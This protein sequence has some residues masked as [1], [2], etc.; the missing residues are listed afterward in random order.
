MHCAAP[1]A[2]RCGDCDTELPAGA[3]FCPQCAR[4]A[5]AASPVPI[6][7]RSPVAYTSK[8]RAAKILPSKFAL[9]GERKQV[10]VLFADVKGSL[11]LAEQ[12]DADAWH[13][14]LECFFAILADGAHRF[15]GTV[16]QCTGDGIMALF[17]PSIAH[18]DHAQRACYAGLYVQDELARYAS[19]LKRAQSLS[20]S[21]R[22]GLNS[23]QVVVGRTGDD[24]RMDCTAQGHTLGSA[25][26]LE[27]LAEPNTC[28]VSAA[29]VSLAGGY[30]ALDD[31]GALQVKG[32]STPMRV[33]RLAGTGTSRT[34]FEI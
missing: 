21:T 29:T 3:R 5:T 33:H 12:L 32:L 6:A 15:E 9:D 24:L 31:L 17:G 18:E 25:Q 13:Q 16:N 19:E 28:Y 30:F 1:L 2:V 4:P 8:H 7:P 22:M 14:I 11:E 10:T 23:G 26:R 27:S 20:F 34:R